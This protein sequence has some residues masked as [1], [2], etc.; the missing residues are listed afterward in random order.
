MA[1]FGETDSGLLEGVGWLNYRGKT[2]RKALIGTF[3]N[4]PRIGVAV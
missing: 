3:D 4:W 1:A 2:D